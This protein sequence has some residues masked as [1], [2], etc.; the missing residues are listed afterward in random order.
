MTSRALALLNAHIETS[1]RLRLTEVVERAGLPLPTV[2]R[3][4]AE[5]FAWAPWPARPRSPS[6]QTTRSPDT[7]GRFIEQEL[8]T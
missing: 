7:P 3:L 2:R 5:L 8:F 1:R 6:S 4:R